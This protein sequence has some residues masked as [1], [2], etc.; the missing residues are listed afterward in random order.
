MKVLKKTTYFKDILERKKLRREE[1]LDEL[2]T[3]LATCT[4]EL[5]NAEKL[6]NTFHSK[7][8]VK[9]SKET[10]SSYIQITDN[11]SDAQTKKRE[12]R[13]FI[14]LNDQIKKIIVINR[15]VKETKDENGFT[16]IGITDFLLGL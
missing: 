10:V 5:L 3:I 6:S 14:L 16:I 8:K 9:I 7:R 15:P 4:G 11:I 1:A 13:P 12:V 2:C